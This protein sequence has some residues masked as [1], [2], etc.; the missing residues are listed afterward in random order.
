MIINR[1]DKGQI[2]RARLEAG[3]KELKL[4]LVPLKILFNFSRFK[5]ALNWNWFLR[6]LRRDLNSLNSDKALVK[7][8]LT[9]VYRVHPY[10]K[11][12]MIRQRRYIKRWGLHLSISL[13]QNKHE[14]YFKKKQDYWCI[15][16]FISM[17]VHTP[18]TIKT[19]NKTISEVTS[20]QI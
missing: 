8:V 20:V 5:P 11:F 17:L 1:Q 14:K 2:V 18:T 10:V 3:F 12:L 19:K 15:I 9:M 4:G 16:V 7:H 13:G 6:D